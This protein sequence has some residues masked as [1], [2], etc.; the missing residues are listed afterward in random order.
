MGIDE[1]HTAL[2]GGPS[3]RILSG[4]YKTDVARWLRFEYKTLCGDAE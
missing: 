4:M 1:V 3:E 2:A